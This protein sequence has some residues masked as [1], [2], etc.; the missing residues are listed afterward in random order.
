[1]GTPTPG[2]AALPDLTSA[3][4]FANRNIMPVGGFNND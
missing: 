2:V 4:I 3:S 1:M